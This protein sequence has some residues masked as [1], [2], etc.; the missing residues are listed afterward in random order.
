MKTQIRST[1]PMASFNLVEDWIEVDL[2]DDEGSLMETM[3][4]HPFQESGETKVQFRKRVKAGIA[5]RMAPVEAPAPAK[6]ADT[7]IAEASL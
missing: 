2:L 7:E 5:V 1:K 3:V 4:F 6:R